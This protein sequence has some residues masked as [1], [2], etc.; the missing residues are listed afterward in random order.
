M[1]V[2]I[3]SHKITN[4]IK[5]IFNLIFVDLLQTEIELTTD[6][7][8]FQS[9][10]GVKLHYGKT[11]FN[12][13]LFF[14]ADKLLFERGI[15]H[16]DLTFIE[17]NSLPA[18][19]PVYVN[20]TVIPFD[21]FSASFYLV[22]RYEEYLPH[23]EDQYGRF[24]ADESI[25][26]QKG[27]LRKPLVNIWALEIAS[28]IQ[29][30]FPDFTWTSPTYKFIPT[31]DI[32]AAWSYRGKGVFRTAG[33]YLAS[34]LKL[35]FS[36][37][38]ERT[39]VLTGVKKDPFDTYQFQFDIHKKFKLK[40][41]YFILFA[42]YGFNDK[43]IPVRNQRFQTLI[44]SLDDRAQVGIH[45]SYNSN[46]YL[47]K[48][49]EEVEGLS[50]VIHRPITASRQ[51]FLKIQL[52]ITYRN[53][54]NF[55]IRDDYSM[56]FA[57][58]PGFRAGICSTFKFYDLD[59]D[60]ATPLNIHPFSYMEGTL[61]DYMQVETD[62]AIQII[63]GLIEEVKAVK[64]TFIP[65]WHNESLSNTKRWEGWQAVYESMITMALP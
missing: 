15:K 2:L 32:D 16:Y 29:K 21:V 24:T 46:D 13:E 63:K 38:A 6:L 36:E 48:L 3:Y 5:Y 55:D 8:S 50:Q 37:I 25:S 30:K 44:K 7:E 22:S 43:N 31:I 23:K 65:I 64:G 57:S 12:D 18:F 42:D 56:G 53:L 45:P 52:P 4:R 60:V 47:R 1:K 62:D 61:R 39:R 51:H 28:I 17:Y 11:I 41:I 33:G 10:E 27:F 54:L 26:F 14:A 49:R 9:Y 58:Q 40:P 35:D 34:A 59:L 19:F 20:E